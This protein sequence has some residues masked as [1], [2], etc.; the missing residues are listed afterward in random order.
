MEIDGDR[1]WASLEEVNS[2]GAR[3]SGGVE[4]LAWSDEEIAARRW[5][6]G[7]CADAGLEVK[8][9]QA[10]NVW[11]FSGGPPA[12]VLGSH[13][14][15]VP[16]GGRFDGAL[17][18]VAALEVVRAARE[19]GEAGADRLGLV[20]FTDEEGVRFGIGMTG[21]RAVAGTLG[22]DEL[23][24]A[25]TSGGERYWQVLAQAGVDPERFG[26]ASDR[27]AGIA[28]YLEL[29]VEQGRMLERAGSPIGVVSAIVG[30]VG[31]N[32]EVTG[33]ANHAGTTLQAD[34]RDALVPVA[35]L[36]LAAQDAMG[37][38]LVATVGDAAVI[39]GASNV[40]PGRARA[41][42]DVR[43]TDT[44]RIE[45]AVRQAL[46]AAR[47]AADQNNC[48]LSV[49]E[50]KR[51]APAQMAPDVVQTLRDAARAEGLEAPELASMAGHD[52][53]SLSRAGVPCGMLFVRSR[54]G[55]SHSPAEHSGRED[56]LAGARVLGRAALALAQRL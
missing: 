24:E 13:L 8:H 38:D 30:L 35:A 54:D 21:S 7:R 27:R 17:G 36:V 23:R 3:E 51:L 46:G 55:I 43:S 52:G 10:G 34:R 29:H 53:M 1:L 44:D 28:A 12:V 41:T 6:S 4:R 14:D 40:V 22:E 32:V 48:A 26:D 31:W 50:T 15:T 42:L 16:D 49:E 9:D 39:D 18:V 2:F 56:C 45:A 20:C 33:E 47:T 19:A 11:A 5:L 25:R 37:E